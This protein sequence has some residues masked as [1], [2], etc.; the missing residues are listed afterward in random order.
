[1]DQ[2]GRGRSAALKSSG[3]S[4]PHSLLVVFR[5]LLFFVLSLFI[6]D[7]DRRCVLVIVLKL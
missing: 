1:M 5:V 6:D 4:F 7:L 2:N 3:A